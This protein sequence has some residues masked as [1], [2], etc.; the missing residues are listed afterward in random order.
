LSVLFDWLSFFPPVLLIKLPAFAAPNNYPSLPA[1]LRALAMRASHYE[2]LDPAPRQTAC[3]LVHG[4]GDCANRAKGFDHGKG[5]PK[6]RFERARSLRPKSTAR[7]RQHFDI[8]QFNKAD[9]EASYLGTFQI[10]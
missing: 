4:G 7:I 5:A 9:G 2:L 8:W 1:I 10:F 6:S 3:V